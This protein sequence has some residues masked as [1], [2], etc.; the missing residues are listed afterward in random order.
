M[1]NKMWV[2]HNPDFC[3]QIAVQDAKDFKLL[4]VVS[5]VGLVECK[6]NV[7]ALK[8]LRETPENQTPPLKQIFLDDRI[9]PNK[10]KRGNRFMP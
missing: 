4:R 1:R 2:T 9:A 7:P 6:L 10:E 3:G 8:R 5:L